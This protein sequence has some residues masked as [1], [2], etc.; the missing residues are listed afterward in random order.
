MGTTLSSTDE[1]AF[2][3]QYW[4]KVSMK[5]KTTSARLGVG[6]AQANADLLKNSEIRDGRFIRY[7]G[8]KEEIVI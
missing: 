3:F 2:P 1:S 5:E 8:K 4:E 6:K 7:Y